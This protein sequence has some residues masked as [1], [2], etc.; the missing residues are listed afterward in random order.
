VRFEP[1]RGT[2]LAL[3]RSGILERFKGYRWM[4]LAN[5][6]MLGFRSHAS[7]EVLEGGLIGV[8]DGRR[9][10]VLRADGARFAQARFP[11]GGPRFTVAGQSGLVADASGTRVAFAVTRGNNGY[12]NGGT[13]SLYLLRSGDSQPRPLF[14][15]RVRF[16]SCERWAAL[17]WRDHWLLYA[18]TEGRTIALDSD[19][20]SRTVNLTRVVRRFAAL[21]A[22]RKVDAQVEWAR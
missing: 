7:F 21:D 1:S 3:T 20:P 5:L 13:E 16:A 4:R 19:S 10:G 14:S 6:R 11:P 12:G 17:A 18:T 15:G 22:E 9:V 2:V 8:L